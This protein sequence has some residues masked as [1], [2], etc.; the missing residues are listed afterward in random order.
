[1]THRT[2]IE[3]FGKNKETEH[4]KVRAHMT[5]NVFGVVR[6]CSDLFGFVRMAFL[7][8][9]AFLNKLH[10]FIPKF[11]KFAVF[12]CVVSISPKWCSLSIFMVKESSNASIPFPFWLK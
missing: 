4:W 1:M 8:I 3:Q 6:I 11:P 7:R 2:E 9:L 12:M 10:Q 5:K